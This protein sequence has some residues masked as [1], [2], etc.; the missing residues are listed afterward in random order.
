MQP[1][2]PSLE[3][4][5]VL[6]VHNAKFKGFR[7]LNAV[8]KATGKDSLANSSVSKVEL[9]TSIQKNVISLERVKMKMAGFRLRLEGQTSFDGHV[10]FKMR[11]G[12]PP[13]GIIGIPISITGTQN[14]PKVKIGKTDEERLGENEDSEND[15]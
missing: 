8:S 6:S 1:I 11:L 7:L 14:A 9:R 10:K 12:L 15:Q 2:Y 13:L 3:G 4:S 5:G